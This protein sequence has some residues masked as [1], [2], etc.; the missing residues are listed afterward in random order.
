MKQKTSK[1]VNKKS[2]KITSKKVNKESSKKT[3]KK[4]NK[5]S[6][7]IT[8]NTTTS[9]SKKICLND[10]NVTELIL[11]YLVPIFQYLSIEMSDYNMKLKTTK[12]L[13]T[14]VML[15][16]ILGSQED[17]KT[18]VN[19]CDTENINKRFSKI[20]TKKNNKEEKKK[21]LDKL[22]LDIKQKNIRNRYF[23]YILMTH[24]SMKKKKI[25]IIILKLMNGSQDMY[26][27]LRNQLI[28]RK[29]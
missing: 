12:C 15:V 20:K 21:I 24:S 1:K 22:N 5:K 17:I 11:K 8:T 23:Y 9:N 25:L 10:C 28:V 7:K 2:S 18:K 16:Y 13:N 27:L 4:V 29:I 26:I 3:S 14:A 6:S 19:Y